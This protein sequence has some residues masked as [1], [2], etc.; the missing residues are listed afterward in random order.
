MECERRWDSRTKC[1][2]GRSD[3]WN[4]RNAKGWE[5]SEECLFLLVVGHRH[6]RREEKRRAAQ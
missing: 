1:V 2:G 4:E 6:E 5:K 3:E